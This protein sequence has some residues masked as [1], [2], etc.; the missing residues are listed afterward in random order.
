MA[1]TLGQLKNRILF[2]TNR[3]AGTYGA[4][5]NAAIVTAISYMQNKYFWKF[6]KS[7]QVTILNGKNSVQLPDDYQNMLTVQFGIGNTLYSLKQGFLN[8]SFEDLLAL[9]QTTAQVGVPQWY[10]IFN[11]VLYVYPLTPGDTIFNIYYC[12]RDAFLPATDA[13]SSIWFDSDT[14]DLIRMKAMELFYQDTLQSTENA[15]V[16]ASSFKD[17][18]QNF[19]QNNTNKQ[20][21]L[22]LS[23]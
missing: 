13:D 2:D 12:F 6:K 10:A 21:Y 14:V 9:Y 8:K 22:M 16:Y 1:V 5:V 19:A 15:E 18:E 4:A 17:F 7:G 23:V 11:N 20:Q 3:D